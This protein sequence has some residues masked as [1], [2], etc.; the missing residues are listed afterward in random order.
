MSDRDK[1]IN[2]LKTLP[3]NIS[4]KEILDTLYNVFDLKDKLENIN[5]DEAIS[6]EDFEREIEKW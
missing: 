6:S 2:L 4:L 5:E 1:A 3:M